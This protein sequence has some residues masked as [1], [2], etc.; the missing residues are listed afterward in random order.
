MLEKAGVFGVEIR[1]FID[2]RALS[3]LLHECCDLDT[4]HLS[5]QVKD[6]FLSSED[7]IR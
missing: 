7:S 5:K 3:R 2:L 1:L 6:F 4:S